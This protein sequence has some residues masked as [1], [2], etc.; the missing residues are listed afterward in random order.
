[1]NLLILESPGKVKK[2][3]SFLGSDWK[4]VASVGHVRDLPERELGIAL[5][6]FTP[7]YTPTERGKDVLA[8]LKGLAAS[9]SAVYLA[10]DPDREGEAIAWHVAEALRLKNPK[11]VTYGEITASAIQAALKT[12]RNLDMALVA[13]QEARRVL[14]RFCGYLVSGPLSRSAGTR[15]SAG[16]VQSPAV[17]LVVE[18]ERAISNFVSVTHYGAELTL[19]GGWQAA[20][21][22][23]PWLQEGQEYLLDKAL[24]EKAAALRSLTVKECKETESRTAPPAPFTT[25]S[26]QQAASNALKFTPKQTMQLAQK[27]YEGGHCTYMRTD[28]PNL[29]VEAVSEIRAFCESQGWPLVDKPRTWKSKEGAQ[30]AHEAIRPTHIEVEEAGDTPDEKA[31]YRLIRLRA[32]ASQLADA[33]YD[34]RIVRLG[35]AL[36]GKEAL[37]E[38]RGRVL[39]EPGWKSLTATDEATQDED[40]EGEGQDNPVPLLTEGQSITVASGKVLTKKTKPPTRFSEASLVRELENRGIGRPAT[41]AAIVDTIMSR[42]Y[43]R[44]EKR[45]LV[46]TPVGEQVVDLLSGAFSFLDYEFTKGMEDNL[47]AIAGGKAAYREVM[48]KAHAQLVREVTTFTSKYP[49][50]ERNAPEATNFVCDA[51]G[52][53]LVHMKG[54][55]RDGSGEYDFFSCSDR[56]CNA[57]YPNVDGKPGEVR[58]KPETTKFKCTCGKAL[59]RRESAKGPFFGCSG[60]PGCKKHFQ[61]GEDGRP[62]IDAKKGGKK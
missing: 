1:M 37:F 39:R 16:R 19:E 9:A 22:T 7:T 52:K 48:S 50:Q 35:E 2:V 32:L 3:Q 46:P 10:T 60:Y 55:R 62:I 21:I 43:V 4:V 42:E 11:R 25:S 40:A 41:F 8:R 36:G 58:K 56:A 33:V 12:P 54:Q 53:A 26:L 49:G 18:R 5:P 17:R 57:S 14:D 29:S 45:F 28:S 24:A 27:I 15:L 23:K 20:W 6:D 30:E 34:V 44:V 38:A 61:V 59:V 13:A 47:D 51:C 31:L